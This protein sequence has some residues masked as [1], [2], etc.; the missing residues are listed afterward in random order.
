MAGLVKDAHDHDKR[1]YCLAFQVDYWNN[2]GW[3]DLYSSAAYSQRQYAYAKALKS[4]HVYTPQMIVNGTDEFVG[5]NKALAS[6]GVEAALKKPASAT[7]RLHWDKK[8]DAQTLILR[9]ET[10]SAPA[11]AVLN[12]ALVE[13]GLVGKVSRRRERRPNAAT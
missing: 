10:K 9:Y 7:I 5:S 12:V 4:D 2:L 1:V 3:T 8:S 6:K 11:R 13:R